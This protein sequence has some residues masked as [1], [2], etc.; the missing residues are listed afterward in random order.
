MKRKRYNTLGGRAYPC[1][2]Y[3]L[4][5]AE[6]PDFDLDRINRRDNDVEL[7][8]IHDF[9]RM[10]WKGE[11]FQKMIQKPP[12]FSQ[13]IKIICDLANYISYLYYICVNKTHES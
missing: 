8:Y 12:I 1:Y 6:I 5:S 10:L 2:L 7:I 4:V 9:L 13:I 11:L 3:P